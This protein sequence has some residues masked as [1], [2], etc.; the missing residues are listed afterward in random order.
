VHAWHVRRLTDLPVAGRSLVIEL[1]VRRLVCQATAC[2]Q[3]TFREQV[4][5]LALRYARQTRRLTTLIGQLAITLAG[6]A[7]AAVLS[8]LGVAV[9]R[10]TVLRV[11]MALPI[12]SAPTPTVLSVDDVA[13]RRGHRYATVL[14]DAVT[15]QRV[16]VLPDRKAATVSTWLRERPGVEIVCRDGSAAYAEAIRQGAPEAVQVSDRWHLWHGLGGAV[17]KTVIAH[18][19]CWRTPPQQ[20][21]QP[22]QPE[23]AIDQRTRARHAAVHELLGQGV[24]LLECARRLGWALNTV[25]R[26]ARAATPEQLQRPPRYGRTLVDPYRDHLRRRLAAEPDIAVTRL[27]AEI[28]EL[29]YTGSANLLVRYLNQG[30]AQAERATPSPRRLVG[31]IMSRPADLPD[32][33]RSHLDELLASC[34]PLTVLVEHVRTFADLLTTRR[35]NDLEDWISAVEASDLPALHAFVRGLGKDLD[36]VA[37]G[38]SLPYSNGPIE[39]TNTKFKLLKR[40]MYGRAGFTLLRQRILLS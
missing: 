27:L 26:Y 6:R 9:S 29:G 21:S 8:G 3:R 17:E 10:S 16:D 28:R 14:I 7:G 37:A 39:G 18:S 22:S 11:L 33:D 34:P 31:W 4:P 12:P 20:P 35:G 40:Q 36:A 32:H 23:R 15:H 24:G 30:R 38:L 13:L 1:R 25:K 5:E 19:T 2:P